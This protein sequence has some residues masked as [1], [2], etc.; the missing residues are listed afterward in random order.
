MGT[1]ITIHAPFD[2]ATLKDIP[3]GMLHSGTYQP[4][5]EFSE[6]SLIQLRDTI[7]LLGVLEPLI[8]R[9]SQQHAGQYEIIAGERRFRAATLAGLASVPC[10]V[11]AFLN[12]KA[13][14]AALI[15][16]TCREDLNP[17]DKAHAMQRFVI[18]FDYTHE[19]IGALLGISR[20]NISNILRLLRLDGRVQH[21]LRSGSLSEG[22]GKLLAGIS[23]DRQYEFAYEAIKRG[24]SVNILDEAIKN[25]A[26]RK[27]SRKPQKDESVC[28]TT[29]L[30]YRLTE[31]FGHPVK[32]SI[33]RD[34]SG[35]FRILFCNRQHMLDIMRRLGDDSDDPP[36]GDS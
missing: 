25:K 30:G 7:A 20:S 5:R 32:A 16:N 33:N 4:R 27:N 31:K 34:E 36:L 14:Q 18:E 12:E 29:Q 28:H 13:A 2:K 19:E 23:Y 11:A 15:E 3:L 21:W 1:I 8:V 22:H 17:I 24:W 35:S 6:E 10:M 9:P 26:D